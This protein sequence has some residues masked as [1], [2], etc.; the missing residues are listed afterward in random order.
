MGLASSK[1]ANSIAARNGGVGG[2]KCGSVIVET[3][4]PDIQQ[5]CS[6]LPSPSSGISSIDTWKPSS[7]HVRQ[8]SIRSRNLQPM[9]DISELDR[10]FAKVLASMDL[11]PDKAKLLK[12]Y[13]NEKKWDIICDQEM[14]HAKDPP[15]HYLTKLRTYLDPKASRSHRKRKMVGES[16]STQVLRDLEISLRTNH[17][18]WVK[19]FLDTENQGLDALIDYLSFRLAM[20][21]HEQRIQEAKSESD[22]GLNPKDTTLTSYGSNETNH[23]LGV[24]GF[25]RPGL[26][27]M[28]DSPSIRRR[29][30]HIAKL[31][32]GLTT[33]DIHVCNMCMRAI[34]NNKYGFNMVLQHREAINCIAL[35][36]THKSLR[37]KALVLELLA[38]ICL[39]KGGHEIILSAFDNFKVVCSEQRRF[40]TLMEY[41]MN[42]ELFNIDFMVA[43]MQFVNIVVHSVEDMNYRVHLQYEFTALGL[44]DYLE[45]L[46]LTESEELQVQI[47]AYLD[48]VFDV[49]ALMEDSETKTA[50]LERVNELEDELGRAL[51]QASEIEREALFKIGELESEL[52]QTR[53]ERDDL[54]NKQRTVEE[55][56]TKLKRALKEHE[57]ESKSRQ[58]MLLELENLTKTLPKGTSIADV[59]NLLAKG[60]KLSELSPTS[61]GADKAAP[62][63]PPPPAPPAAPMPPP[64]PCPPAPPALPNLN[65]DAPRAPPKPPSFIPPP[66]AGPGGFMNFGGAI[67]CTDGAMTIKRK[68]QTKYKLPTLNWVALKP[69]QVRG[70]IFNELDDEKLHRH[71][72][73]IDFEERFKI[74]MGGPLTN[75]SCDM[76]GLSTFPSKRFKKPEHISLLEHTRLRNIA[77]SRRKLEMPVESVIKAIN[78]LD[79]KQLSL[80]NVELLQKMVPT[81]QEQKLYKEYVIEK[82]DL[83]LLTEE[84]KFMLQLTKVERISSKLSIMNYIGNFFDSLHLIN[85]QIYAI[86]SASSSIKSSKKFRSL[87]EVILA[88]GNYLNSSKRGPAYGFKLQSLDTLLDTKSNDKRMSLMHYIVATV[89]QKF[90]ELLNFDSE[91]F[92]ID[93]A[94]QVSLEI[95]ITDVSELEKGMEAVR[96]EADLRGKG[97][98]N[99]VL[100]DFLNNSEEKL[101]KIRTDCKTAQDSFKECIEYFGESSRSSDANAFFSLLVRFV[102]AFK[103]CDQENE[104]RRRLELAALQAANKKDE[105]EEQVV[106]RNNKLNNQKKQQEAVINELKTKTNSVREKKLLQQDEVYNGALEDIL[107]GLKNEPYRR[108]DAVRRSQRRRI[109]SNRLS[110]TMEELEF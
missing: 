22:E 32:M 29:S 62:P 38:A 77:I 63:V 87:L 58:S 104:Q 99:H 4:H 68:V 80:E 100:R 101:K 5:P 9:P 59:S 82:K 103:T 13:D 60:G 26:G 110:R 20:M 91:L 95:L 56:I 28:M 40:Q 61:N 73:F 37:T 88:F 66:P 15:A 45:K 71:I 16:T 85:P 50:A 18:E 51:D 31:N 106:L 72:D 36:L 6:L 1:A 64:P 86:I 98:H 108:A 25:M 24:N 19:E 79:L 35:S 44:D 43:C 14:V 57:Q 3:H 83:N 41:F 52:S 84:D 74:G 2:S 17:I 49:A 55:E 47:S 12:N 33:D 53:A 90:P 23:K 105:L 94:A 48:N 69:N 11:P 8:A 92:C 34:M 70:T 7:C 96:K 54:F 21:R 39:V 65:G 109:D 102:R 27:D 76:D 10:R 81:D 97:T 42:Y 75:G 89:R 93:K 67:H 46:R 78:N 107:L 30:R